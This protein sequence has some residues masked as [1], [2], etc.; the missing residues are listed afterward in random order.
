MRPISVG[1]LENQKTLLEPRRR[2]FTIPLSYFNIT[3]IRT[4]DIPD[5]FYRPNIGRYLML[6]HRMEKG[7]ENIDFRWK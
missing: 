1:V 4:E 7:M 2:L 6:F 5:V 3:R